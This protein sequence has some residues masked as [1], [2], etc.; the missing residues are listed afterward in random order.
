MVKTCILGI[1]LTCTAPVCMAQSTSGSSSEDSAAVV[2]AI[3]ALE[4][5]I[6]AQLG[7]LHATG[8]P[9][10][11]R[12]L[13]NELADSTDGLARRWRLVF[14]EEDDG[15]MMASAYNGLAAALDATNPGAGAAYRGV[16]AALQY[17]DPAPYRPARYQALRSISDRA[18]SLAR[19]KDPVRVQR[20]LGKLD[21][22][23]V[24]LATAP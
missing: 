16:A 8:D 15:W 4:P 21:A 2:A 6:A 17:S 7:T 20:L 5:W 19:A 3:H 12:S 23:H 22:A 1:W 11:R 24:E 18:W 9:V 13:A 10:Q 14:P